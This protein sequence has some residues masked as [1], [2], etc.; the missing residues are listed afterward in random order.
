[1]LGL[2]KEKSGKRVRQTVNS[3]NVGGSAGRVLQLFDSSFILSP[4]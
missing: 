2:E 1:M 4:S 3:G